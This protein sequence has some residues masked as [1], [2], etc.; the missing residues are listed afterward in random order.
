MSTKKES[1]AARQ[2]SRRKSLRYHSDQ[3]KPEIP[4]YL[5]AVSAS[6]E[7]EAICM[8]EP[9][10]QA[11][12]KPVTKVSTKYE[13]GF[14]TITMNRTSIFSII[15][16]IALLGLCFFGMGF[17]VSQ[18]YFATPTIQT[19]A[20]PAPAQPAIQP[21][22]EA[23]T[24]TPTDEQGKLAELAQS[25]SGQFGAN[26]LPGAEGVEKVNEA[27]SGVQIAADI[28]SKA[29][30]GITK[31]I[32][33]ST[34]PSSTIGETKKNLPTPTTTPTT[35]VKGNYGIILG[36]ASTEDSAKAMQEE[37]KRVKLETI[38]VTT[39]QN[40]PRPG[41]A[42]IAGRYST[43][44]DALAAIETLPK[45]YSLWGKVYK[46]EQTNGNSRPGGN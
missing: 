1:Q 28:T 25:L 30:E 35:N 6:E 44:S 27:V 15:L 11:T 37:I 32:P 33:D 23:Q 10:P 2:S 46:F 7:E 36:E 29:K 22:P 5:R 9:E 24:A 45:P 8:A 12:K 16:G 13:E 26:Q 19:T 43:Y 31:T 38:I 18:M 4:A 42:I 34:P 3:E 14:I 40:D 20:A 39:T 17:L 21:T 41:Y